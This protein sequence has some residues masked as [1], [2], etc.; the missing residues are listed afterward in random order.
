MTLTTISTDSTRP[1]TPKATTNGTIGAIPE[2]SWSLTARYDCVAVT[3][4]GG[5]ARFSAATSARIAA[6]VLALANRYSICTVGGAPRARRA[7]ISRGTT[8]PSAD[9]LIELAMPTTVNLGR[10]G[11]PT[12]VTCAPGGK[13]NWKSLEST[14]SPGR[15]AH[16][17]CRRVRS[18]S[19]PPGEARPTSVSGGPVNCPPDPGGPGSCGVMVTSGYGPA[20]AVTCGSRVL[21]AS[22]A[23]V[24]LPE[25]M[26]ATRCA[27][28]WAAKALSNGAFETTTR[29]RASTQAPV[30]IVTTRP[31]TSVCTRLRASPPRSARATAPARPRL[32][33]RPPALRWWR[34]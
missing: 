34:H 25:S 9:W 32:I 18:S 11:T 19:G 17:P 30:E 4:P 24:A 22:W 16:R 29:P 7:A 28:C 8:Q 13:P 31:I 20:A 15:C 5:S 23:V 2:D 27:P 14:I 10:P 21:A 6:A 12:A 26:A 33:A 3:A 1:M